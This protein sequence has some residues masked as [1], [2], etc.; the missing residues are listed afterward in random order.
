MASTNQTTHYELSQYVGSD[1]PTYLV[2]YNQDMSK[3]DAGIYAAKSEADTNSGAIGTLSELTTTAKTDLVAS[4]NEINTSASKIGDLTNLT[5]TAKTS[6]V[7][8]INEVDSET[9][10][11]GDL[12][13]LTTTS[14]STLVAAVNELD[15]EIGDLSTLNTT[16][17]S[18]LVAAVNS[19]EGEIGDMSELATTDKTYIVDAINEVKYD[20]MDVEDYFTL[21]DFRTLTNP[22][23]SSTTGGTISGSIASHEISIA[24]NEAG[25]FGKVYGQISLSGVNGYA[26]VT[27]KNT[28]IMGI[29]EAITI[30]PVGVAFGVANNNV[31]SVGVVALV[32]SPPAGNETSASLSIRAG[33]WNTSS[34]LVYAMPC[35][36]YFKDFGDTE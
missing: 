4:V 16:Y 23:L 24:L 32:I 36:Y 29:T 27:F 9:S 33:A 19:V 35:L 30:R 18:D 13:N 14:K 31:G 3:I 7:A 2:D 5:T 1:K 15:G 34:T 26:S 28:G 6:L 22:T 8:A 20:V 25:T 11:I 10:S 21:T 17:K 12:T